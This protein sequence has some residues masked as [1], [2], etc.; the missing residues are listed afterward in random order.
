V[1]PVGVQTIECVVPTPQTSVTAGADTTI[2]VTLVIVKG[3]GLKEVTP[4]SVV[5]MRLIL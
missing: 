4:A 3:A 2:F 1:V 5:F